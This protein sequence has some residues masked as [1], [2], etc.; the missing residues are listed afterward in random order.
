MCRNYAP[1]F[2]RR[3]RSC[4]LIA[5]SGD[6]VRYLVNGIRDTFDFPGTPIRIL[7]RGG[8]NPYADD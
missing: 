5:G 7:K 1:W 4:A 2:A 8:K 6:Y 3:R